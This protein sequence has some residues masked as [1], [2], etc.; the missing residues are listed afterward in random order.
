MSIITNV[1]R[2]GAAAILIALCA[3]TPAW[4]G[5]QSVA[6]QWNDEL[7]EAIRNDFARPT[8]HARNLYH[9]AVAMW[10]AWAAYDPVAVGVFVNDNE[11][12]P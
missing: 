1:R 6:R 11:E 4:A 12:L 3:P 10:D 8:V 7:L 2:A 5:G 9:V